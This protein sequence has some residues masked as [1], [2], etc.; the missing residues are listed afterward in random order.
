MNASRAAARTIAEVLCQAL[1]LGVARIAF[2]VLDPVTCVVCNAGL[3][4]NTAQIAL[5]RF[6]VLADVIE[7]V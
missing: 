4:C 5:V 1:H 7:E 6:K 2:S 3:I